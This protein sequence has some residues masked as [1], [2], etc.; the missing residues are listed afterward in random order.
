[1]VEFIELYMYIDRIRF[2]ENI[3]WDFKVKTYEKLEEFYL[4]NPKPDQNF[5]IKNI[6]GDRFQQKKKEA[7]STISCVISIAMP[8]YRNK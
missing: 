6:C 3:N 5:I 2:Y 7:N 4:T 1:M 8:S